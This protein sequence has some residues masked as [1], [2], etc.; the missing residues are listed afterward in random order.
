MYKVIKFVS[1]SFDCTVAYPNALFGLGLRR[2]S[3][4]KHNKEE[5]FSQVSLLN[6]L[7]RRRY[8]EKEAEI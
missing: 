2:V 3:E 1:H 6:V 7:W 5:D 4:Q 8:K